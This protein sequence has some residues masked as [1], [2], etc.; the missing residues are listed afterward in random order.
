MPIIKQQHPVSIIENEREVSRDFEGLCESLN[1]PDHKARRWAVR[2][3]A[4]YKE[5]SD[6]LATRLNIETEPSVRTVILDTLAKFGDETAISAIVNCLR[7]D[8]A[9]L[10]N[11]AI[12]VLKNIPEEVAPIIESLLTDEDS[13]VRIFAVNILESLRHEN[14][15]KWLID[16]IEHD[17]HV[18]VCST[19][20]DLLSEVGTEKAIQALKNLKQ[21]F[22]HEPY[23]CFSVDLALKRIQEG[24]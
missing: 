5:A 14:V 11:E 22:A 3:L 6:V 16:V 23:V 24:G 2:D 1:N 20:V 4:Q 18:N 8:E 10:R 7:S 12:D 9:G 21:R 17:P 15:E 13:D 19:A